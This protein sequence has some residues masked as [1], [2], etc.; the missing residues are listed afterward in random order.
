LPPPLLALL[1]RRRSRISRIWDQICIP[2]I[3][4]SLSGVDEFGSTVDEGD[5]GE[6]CD[7]CGST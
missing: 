2:G 5:I 6:L 1:L 7:S 4:V 3:I